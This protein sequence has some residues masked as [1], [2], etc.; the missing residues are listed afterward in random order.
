[1]IASAEGGVVLNASTREA[2]DDTILSPRFYTTDFA[3]MDKLDVGGVR[4]QWDALI[5]EMRDDPN[6]GHFKKTDD[7]YTD[8][9]KMD[10]ALRK[11]VLDFLV[12]SLT[13]EFSGCV[14]Y[15]EIKKRITNK[16][17]RELFTFMSRD[18]ARH[19]GFINE[20]L[21]DHGIGV[22]LG[23]LTRA[24]KYTYFK[25]K[26]IFYAT[27]LSE[28]IGYARY[29]TIYR[30]LERN[31][32]RMFHPIFKW[33]EKWCNDEFRHGEAF[34]LL[35]RSDPSLLEGRNKLWIKF[36]LL[37]V[38]ATMYVRDHMR[39]EFHKALGM[40]PTDYDMRV[41]RITSDISKQ[42][43]PL[44]IDID[45]PAFLPT[46]ER[47]SRISD[48]MGEAKRAGGLMGRLKRVGLGVAAGVAFVRLY[49]I[50]SK[51]NVL[52]ADARLVPAW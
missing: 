9:D 35:M 28:K 13:A 32:D 25:P 38:F 5:K 48:G 41:F 47:L 37:A 34:A 22:D 8:L 16:D 49:A 11:E 4:L 1:M 44:T 12:S 51:P 50:P 31:P 26:F 15:A 29:I 6:R 2:T 39:P 23:F 52:P 14:L 3:A 19:A 10:P 30:Q 40:D 27:Y 21:K 18:E 17:I 20:T 43:F 33:F 46:L 24:K 7:L 45:H 42:V 36:F